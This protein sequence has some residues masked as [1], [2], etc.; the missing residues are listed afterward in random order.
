MEVV[1]LMILVTW[2]VTPCRLVKSNRHFEGSSYLE[3]QSQAAQNECLTTYI[4][5]LKVTGL[6]VLQAVGICL[7][8][9]VCIIPKNSTRLDSHPFL[10]ISVSTGKYGS[11]A[12]F[13][14]LW[15]TGP[16]EGH[17]GYSKESEKMPTVQGKFI[18]FTPQMRAREWSI[19]PTIPNKV[20]DGS[21]QS[22][23]R[24]VS[25][26]LGESGPVRR[27][28]GL[29]AAVNHLMKRKSFASSENRSMVLRCPA[30][31]FVTRVT[32]LSQFNNIVCRLNRGNVCLI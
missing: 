19:P 25:F 7:K 16:M 27:W 2:D 13:P 4:S 28:A 24:T 14:N 12:V 17:D 20:P 29:R 30:Y 6:K 21:Q 15:A 8:T 18:P 31:R 9:A 23:S 11:R 3:L 22:A 32:E 1:L 26:T 5:T 10:A